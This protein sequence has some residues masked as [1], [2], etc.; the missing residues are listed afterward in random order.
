MKNGVCVQCGSTADIGLIFCKKCGATLRPPV[1]L[2][3]SPTQD[4]T[5]PDTFSAKVV[6]V[7]FLGCAVIDFIWGYIHQR[8]VPAGVIS[9]VGGLFGTAWYLLLGKWLLKSL[10]QNNDKSSLSRR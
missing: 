9:A 2:V 8:S 5:P 3:P 1:P 10:S 4:T 7:I 6:L